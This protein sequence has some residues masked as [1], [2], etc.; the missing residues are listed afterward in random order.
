M[1]C[2]PAKITLSLIRAFT[3]ARQLNRSDKTI[4]KALTRT[5]EVVQAVES[6][7]QE[8]AVKFEDVAKRMIG[9]I[10]DED[11]TKLDGYRRTLSAAVATD[12]AACLR[13]A[14]SQAGSTEVRIVIVGNDGTKT[15]VAMQVK[16]QPQVG[17]DEGSF[18]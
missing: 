6:I 2:P 5:A 14:A 16:G 8:L 7:R 15:A 1:R 13:N 12:K 17:T 11:I 10:T 4:K 18:E 9:S 3:I